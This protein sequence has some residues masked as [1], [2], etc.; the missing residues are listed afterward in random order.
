MKEV[1]NI[2]YG[3]T[4]DSIEDVDRARKTTVRPFSTLV[5]LEDPGELPFFVFVLGFQFVH[6]CV[7][8]SPPISAPRFIGVLCSVPSRTDISFPGIPFQVASSADVAPDEKG[9]ASPDFKTVVARSFTAP[10]ISIGVKAPILPNSEESGLVSD[11]VNNTTETPVS[12]RAISAVSE[13]KSLETFSLSGNTCQVLSTPDIFKDTSTNKV[14]CGKVLRAEAISQIISLLLLL[15]LTIRSSTFKSLQELLNLQCFSIRSTGNVQGSS[16]STAFGTLESSYQFYKMMAI[17][18]SPQKPVPPWIFHLTS[19]KQT[20]VPIQD[21]GTSVVAS[22][23]KEPESYSTKVFK[24]WTS[25][26][27]SHKFK[28][29]FARAP[30]STL[31]ELCT[32]KEVIVYVR[33]LTLIQAF[34]DQSDKSDHADDANKS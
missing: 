5:C 9:K 24:V 16:T 11:S 31:Q 29:Y 2:D 21:S 4:G 10:K 7:A 20:L 13:L 28:T 6:V 14:T 23:L 32:T 30:S 25:D 8:L 3:T 22:K 12:I 17:F 33:R 1:C 34:N 15:A 26:A 19:M 18:R 27:R